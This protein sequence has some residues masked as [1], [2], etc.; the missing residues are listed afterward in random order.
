MSKQIT[1]PTR[2]KT[3]KQIRLSRK[4]YDYLASYGTCTDTFD[5]VLTKIIEQHNKLIQ[6]KEAISKS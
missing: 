5:S 2:L 1:T 4:N 3:G 6:K